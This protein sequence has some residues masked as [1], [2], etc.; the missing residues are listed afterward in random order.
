MTLGY[1][2]YQF[3]KWRQGAEMDRENEK[4]RLLLSQAH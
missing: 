4:E 2:G 3:E 1:V